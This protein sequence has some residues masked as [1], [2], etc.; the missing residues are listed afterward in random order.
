MNEHEN[1]NNP[2]S[3][4][5]NPATEETPQ[6]QS[7][8]DYHKENG[9]RFELRSN[10]STE[11]EVLGRYATREEADKAL[12]AKMDEIYGARMAAVSAGDLPV[13]ADMG[14]RSHTNASQEARE[15]AK[16]LEQKA[17]E[18]KDLDDKKSL[19]E[20]SESHQL[21]EPGTQTNDPQAQG[22]AQNAVRDED[23]AKH[24]NAH[25]HGKHNRG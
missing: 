6:A 17:L 23:N 20:N 25:G 16:S 21:G 7:P 11:A 3:N 14:V 1:P 5:K 10:P 13:I 8:S 15:A 12:K 24:G 19:Q 9:E 4:E 18:K 2:P 22:D